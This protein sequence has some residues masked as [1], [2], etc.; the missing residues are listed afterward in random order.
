[1]AWNGT[2]DF[3]ECNPSNSAPGRVKIAIRVGGI[4]HAG[5]IDQLS[6]QVKNSLRGQIWKLLESFPLDLD[7]SVCVCV[8]VCVCVK[9]KF[10]SDNYTTR[11]IIISSVL[12]YALPWVKRTHDPWS[13]LGLGM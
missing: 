2:G 12:Q 7:S 4:N 5:F 13:R 6:K 1:M 10:I 9:F 11:D 3:L 8:C